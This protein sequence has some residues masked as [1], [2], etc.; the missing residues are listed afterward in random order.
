MNKVLVRVFFPRINEWYE[1]WIP[2]NQKISSIIA[3]LLKGINELNNE[4][5]KLNDLPV[6][7]NRA[8]GEYYDFNIIVENTNIRNGTEL[9]LM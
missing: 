9:I 1:I 4:D 8:T 6:L 2:L 5:Y 3:Q 7:Y